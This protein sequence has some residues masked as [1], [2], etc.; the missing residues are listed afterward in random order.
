MEI[1]TCQ[2]KTG[3][4]SPAGAGNGREGTQ[5]AELGEFTYG[6]F[7]IEKTKNKEMEKW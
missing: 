5:K 4:P 7:S 6:K 3:F 2:Q 1:S